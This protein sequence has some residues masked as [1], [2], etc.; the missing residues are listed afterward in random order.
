MSATLNLP[1]MISRTL[2][3]WYVGEHWGNIQTF[4]L[5][6]T[7]S[8]PHELAHTLSHMTSL[9]RLVVHAAW[10]LD[11][12]QWAFLPSDITL[13]PKLKELECSASSLRLLSWMASLDN[14][15]KGLHLIHI[16]LDGLTTPFTS[17]CVTPFFRRYGRSLKHVYLWLEEVDWLMQASVYQGAFLFFTGVP[18]ANSNWKSLGRP[19]P[20][21]QT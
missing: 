17:H 19:W 5:A 7:Y 18:P 3:W 14:G 1:W 12:W 11:E 21:P 2:D 9:D 13:S 20:M 10:N 4:V 8:W 6:G 16:K 15:P